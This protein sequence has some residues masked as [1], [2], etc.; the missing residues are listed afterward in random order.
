M[1]IVSITVK[2]RPSILDPEGKAIENAL[3]SLSMTGVSR[4]RVGKSIEMLVD[5]ET[6]EEAQGIA[7]ESC[8]KL[9]ANP[10]MEDYCVVVEAAAG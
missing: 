3:H 6:R 8:R 7:E 1:F 4:V 10:V 2:L 9:L 5:A